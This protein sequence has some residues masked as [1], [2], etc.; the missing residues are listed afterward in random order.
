M[1]GFAGALA[2]A[3]WLASEPE[4]AV[5]FPPAPAADEREGPSQSAEAAAIA[6]DDTPSE[7]SPRP[8]TYTPRPAGRK[9]GAAT[10]IFVNFD[11]VTIE[12]CSPSNSHRNCHWL[13]AGRRFAPWSGSFAQ[14]VA[15]LDALRSLVAD[16]GIR[17][18]GQRPPADEPYVMIVYGGDSIEEEALGRAPPGDCWDDLPN[19]IAYV[20]LDG[21]RSDWVNGGASTILHEAGHTWGLDHI[22]LNGALMSPAGGNLLAPPFAGC[23]AIVDGVEFDPAEPSCPEINLELC[24]LSSYQDAGAVLELLFGEPYVDDIAPRLELRRPF[25]G[26]YYQAPA[27]FE[28]ELEITDDLHPQR[29]ELAIEVPGLLDEPSF[30]ELIE[31]RFEVDNLPLGDWTF[32]LRLRDAAGNESQLR[33]RVEVGDDAPVA[34]DGCSCR[35]GPATPDGRGLLSLALLALLRRPRKLGRRRPLLAAEPRR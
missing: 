32:E 3:A 12:S 29:Y 33:F 19:E 8:G 11:G 31:P 2:V 17:V 13:E 5:H 34:D 4:F 1:P 6:F 20:F 22:G 27:S 10:T 14:R 30:R 25:D 16:Y 26:V 24:G 28:V 7:P 23:A 21:E 9:L 35:S 15:I 18:T